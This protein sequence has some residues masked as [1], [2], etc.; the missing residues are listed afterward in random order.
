MSTLKKLKANNLDRLNEIKVTVDQSDLVQS[1]KYVA[2]DM[3]DDAAIFI[4]SKIKRS[5]YI[6]KEGII[7]FLNMKLMQK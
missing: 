3:D 5:L 7:V 1:F 6:I 2:M 4:L